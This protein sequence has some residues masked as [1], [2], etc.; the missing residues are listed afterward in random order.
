MNQS[1][2]Q[3]TLKLLALLLL[4]AGCTD[5]A[6]SESAPPIT[7]VTAQPPTITPS[8]TPTPPP[9]ETATPAPTPTPTFTP[10]S[11]AVP[12]TAG[13]NL[14]AGLLREPVPSG[15]A[16]C[17]VVDLFD[18]PIDPPDAANVSRGG[19]DFGVFRDRFG[20]YH[21]G[22]DWG[23]PAGSSN[24]GAPV[25]SIGHGLVT[26]AQPLGWG[27]DQGVVIVQHT[28]ANGQ[29]LLSFYGHLDPPS[30]VLAPGACV[31]RGQLVGEIGRPRSS[32]H[33]HFE[34]RTQAPY[35]PL[36]GYWPEDPTTQGWLWPS[37]TIWNQRI[38]AQPGV[39]WVR[40]YTTRGITP[41]AQ[42]DDARF[43]IL[44]EG[45]IHTLRLSDGRE[46]ALPLPLDRADAALRHP[47][48]P[49]LYVADRLGRLAAL[50]LS[51]GAAW[52]IDL[53]QA[54]A[55]Q[56]LPLPGGGVLVSL[57]NSLQAVSAAGELLWRQDG[58]ERPF[59]WALAAGAL[60][61][62]TT[63]EGAALWRV[64]GDGPPQQVAPAGG[65]LAVAGETVWIYA[66]TGVYHLSPGA[67][68]AAAPL[69]ALP[70]ARL[71]QGDIIA[72][73]G[74]GALVAHADA[75][76]RRLI[77]FAAD[78][79]VRWDRSIRAVA[80]GVLRL[81]LLDGAVYLVSQGQDGPQGRMTVY[82]VDVTLPGLAHVFEGG[83]RT[84]N[85]RD[86]WATAVEGSAL[87]LNVGGGPLAALDPPRP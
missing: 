67:E 28:L 34:I 35:Q 74:G 50:D 55:P 76:D 73:P 81:L 62:T 71:A 11:T 5:T 30:V 39:K 66:E 7:N 40:P 36:T 52:Q 69:L 42:L 43:A 45:D 14:R 85:S 60:L 61:Y 8:T 1:L 17:G 59:A 44:V 53:A 58:V 15:S 31:A 41:I 64:P 56:L 48:L 21:A 25:Y 87:L 80:G 47:Q 3:L 46:Q 32:P 68:T 12:L 19:G 33:L 83:S 84:A 27:R 9:A 24:F 79:S 20:K 72:L 4:A 82:A 86:A 63:G 6:V 57:R 10:T 23:G 22:E 38:A 70:P 2:T 75:H 37:Q 54:G 26:Y 13:G 18:F 51:G 16:P 77:A 78:G 29:T 65:K 49:R